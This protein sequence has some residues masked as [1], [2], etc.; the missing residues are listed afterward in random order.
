MDIQKAT[1]EKL[2]RAM[3]MGVPIDASILEDLIQKNLLT[4]EAVQRLSAQKN[5]DNKEAGENIV[6]VRISDDV[7][8]IIDDLITSG[9]I[10]SRSEGALYLIMLGIKSHYSFFNQLS[11][12]VVVME[13]QQKKIKNLI[14]NSFILPE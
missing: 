9:H 7:M 13:E 10:N 4:E 12:E 14:E 8:N 11:K 1:E 2:E 5:Y 3:Q 6:P